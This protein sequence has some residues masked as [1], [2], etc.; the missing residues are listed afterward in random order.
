MVGRCPFHEDRGRPNLHLYASGRWICYRCDLR[1][2]VIAFVQRIENATFLEAAALLAGT[3]ARAAPGQVHGRPGLRRVHPAPD[4]PAIVPGEDEYR[5]L[6]AATDLYANRLLTDDR[7]LGYMA[8]RGFPRELLERYRIGFAAGDDLIAYLR[9]RRL[10]LRAAVRIGLLTR[11]GRE[12][13]YGRVV[14][15]ELRQGRPV[16][17]VGRALEL[18]NGQQIVAGPRYLGLPGSKPLLGWDEAVRDRRGVCLVEGPIDLLALRLWGVPGLGLLGNPAPDKLALLDRFERLYLALDRDE[19]G[20]QAT[21]RLAEHF[22][23]R[24]I[25][26]EL[27]AKDLGELARRA[28]GAALFGAAI[29]EAVG[30]HRSERRPR[31]PCAMAA[32]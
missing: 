24:A 12:F 11:D 4:R 32:A 14:F 9:W 21:A 31:P 22:G 20:R 2:D 15:P 17:L 18:P 5:V 10:P 8:A 16:W 28:D 23:E 25:V 26:L 3:M 7:A 30:R 19:G 1:G 29:L 13:L 27:P 6:A